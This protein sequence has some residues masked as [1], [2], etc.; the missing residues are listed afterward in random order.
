MSIMYCEKHNRRWDSDKLDDCPTCEDE[1]MDKGSIE[2]ARSIC[3]EVSGELPDGEQYGSV[4][5]A[6]I[7]SRRVRRAEALLH[8][9]YQVYGGST[10]E[11]HYGQQEMT[12]LDHDTETFLRLKS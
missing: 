10:V 12:A 8:W 6:E 7:L 11:D 1:P 5:C 4:D 2:L 9:W 3:E